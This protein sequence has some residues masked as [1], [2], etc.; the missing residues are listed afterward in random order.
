MPEVPFGPR[1]PRPVAD[2]PPAALADGEVVAKGWLLAIVA[3]RPLR[4]AAAL[5]TA[6]FARDAPALCAAV[7]RAVAS[8]SAL[9]DV[10]RL[11]PRAGSLAGATGPAEV[12][13]A[14]AALRAA[15][16]EA[17][18]TIRLDAATTA[19]LAERLAHV[20]D[21]VA[22][23]AVGGAELRVHDAR[24]D[25]R[26]AIA[27][28]LAAARPF[29]VLAVEGGDAARVA[30][31]DPDRAAGA[32]ARMEEAVRGELRPGDV[33]G[34]EDDG[35]LWVIAADLGGPGARAMAERLADAI[36]AAPVPLAIAIGVAASPADGV[37][38]DALTARA[39]EALFAARAAGVPIA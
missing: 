8:D 31:A 5:P 24:G 16:W 28:L 1:R 15:A 39:D 13:A 23:A 4:D 6:E 35:R 18:T 17:L 14:V 34:R 20:C 22:V 11:A 25:W 38:A 37:D 2:M 7:L 29:A 9:G 36:A 30:A 12:V 21:A 26:A 33:L 10:D 27:R 32:L 3:A 19:A